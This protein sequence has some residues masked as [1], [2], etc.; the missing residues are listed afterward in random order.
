MS[1]TRTIKT[2]KVIKQIKKP[3]GMKIYIEEL[4]VVETC[5]DDCQMM[6]K[7]LRKMG[8]NT[9]GRGTIGEAGSATVNIENK[10]TNEVGYKIKNGKVMFQAFG[11]SNLIN[12]IVFEYNREKIKKRL[13]EKGF[14]FKEGKDNSI[15]ATKIEN[16][17]EKVIEIN[18]DEE[19]VELHSKNFENNKECQKTLD[20]FSD[21]VGD[22][23]IDEH[24]TGEYSDFDYSDIDFVENA[25][26]EKEEELVVENEED[27]A[28][29]KQRSRFD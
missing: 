8:F 21:I 25:D 28:D 27:K 26:D 12:K 14:D 7:V 17:E 6:K 19:K 29:S 20:D 5:I 15:E 2:V 16:G 9:S 3:N 4:I 1:H 18:F 24:D 23:I 13:K 22:D 11:Q 10:I